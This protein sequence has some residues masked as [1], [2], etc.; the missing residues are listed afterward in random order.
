MHPPPPSFPFPWLVPGIAERQE[1]HIRTGQRLDW[2]TERREG[3]CRWGA[4]YVRVRG[5]TAA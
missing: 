1:R 2:A 3:I 4:Y 5:Q